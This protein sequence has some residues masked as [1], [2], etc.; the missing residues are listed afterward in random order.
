MN[1]TEANNLLKKY[2][3]YDETSIEFKA[4]TARD[5][6]AMNVGLRLRI[7]ADFLDKKWRELRDKREIAVKEQGKCC[8]FERISKDKLYLHSECEFINQYKNDVC[9]PCEFY[10]RKIKNIDESMKE[11]SEASEIFRDEANYDDTWK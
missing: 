9:E 11:L 2:D 4:K 8:D 6:G 1:Y 3:I 5:K 7:C 10:Q